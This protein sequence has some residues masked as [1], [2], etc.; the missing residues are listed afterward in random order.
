MASALGDGCMKEGGQ[1][2][3]NVPQARI[4]KLQFAASL[5]KLAIDQSSHVEQKTCKCETEP[6][7]TQLTGYSRANKTDIVLVVRDPTDP[8]KAHHLNP[9][10]LGLLKHQLPKHLSVSSLWSM[11]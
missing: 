5:G 10:L 1:Q 9:N 4:N 8:K 2:A 6:N 3:R 11:T 7:G